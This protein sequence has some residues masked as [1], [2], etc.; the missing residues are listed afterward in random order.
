[1]PSPWAQVSC[2]GLGVHRPQ[3]AGGRRERPGSWMGKGMEGPQAGEE[4]LALGK[5]AQGCRVGGDP[6]R[7][8]SHT[9]AGHTA[10]T[11]DSI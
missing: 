4:R 11:K 5:G 6:K 3:T 8:R 2:R 7:R 10:Q 1:M 9:A